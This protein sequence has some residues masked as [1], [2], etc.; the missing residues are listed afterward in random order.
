M[1]MYHSSLHH[2]VMSM[3]LCNPQVDCLWYVWIIP[4][5]RPISKARRCSFQN[6]LTGDMMFHRASADNISTTG[7]SSLLFEDGQKMTLYFYYKVLEHWSDPTAAK[8]PW[9]Q[10]NGGHS[11]PDPVLTLQEAISA[12]RILSSSG[13]YNL[14]RLWKRGGTLQKR[15]STW[16]RSMRCTTAETLLLFMHS[17]SASADITSHSD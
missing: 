6:I 17:T 9:T 10:I 7:M 11:R 15:L 8:P 1:I 4:I 3:S 14:H 2:R 13:I 5:L 12:H 16:F